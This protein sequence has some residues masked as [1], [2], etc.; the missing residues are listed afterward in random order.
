MKKY[1]AII[2]IIFTLSFTLIISGNIFAQESNSLFSLKNRTEFGN[3]LFCNK[4]YLRAIDEFN[5]VLKNGWD[6][7]LQFKVG[8][9]YYEM[10]RYSK[11]ITEFEKIKNGNS[12]NL[13]AKN[14][15]F[16]SI[17]KLGNY[18]ILR[19]RIDNYFSEIGRE[20][21]LNRLLNYTLLMDDSLLP[22]KSKYLSSFELEEKYKIEEFYNWKSEPPYK[23]PTKAA[24]M[25]A[26]IPGLGKIYVNEIGDGITAFLLTGLFTY[27]SVDKFQNNKTA[28]GWLYASI[29]TFFYAGNVYGSATAVQNYN[30]R[31]KFN[32]DNKVKLYLNEK[33]QYL[34][35]YKIDCN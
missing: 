9:A 20:E 24:I 6:D 16:R 29:A 33:N 3:Y 28:S 34:P 8:I 15:I 10:G 7:E 32:F 31:I 19:N 30:A 22:Q 17:Y 14:E 13:N 5:F 23:S 2:K 27:F 21:N 18:K 26:I 12:L 35:N 11:A 1:S 4:D 25:S